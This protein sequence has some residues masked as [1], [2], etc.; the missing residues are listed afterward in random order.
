MAGSGVGGSR[1]ALWIGGGF[2][3]RRYPVTWRHN[4]GHHNIEHDFVA[5]LIDYG[6]TLGSRTLLGFVPFD[7]DGINQ[8]AVQHPRLKA[9]GANGKYLESQGIHCWGYA[10]NPALAES[11]RLVAEY[12][13]ELYDDF[14]PNAD[15]LLI[16][17]S[18]L[19]L[20]SGPG[21]HHA[22]EFELV[23]E[24]SA[25]YSAGHPDGE[26][27]V[28]PHYFRTDLGRTSWYDDRWRLVFTSH[29]T[30]LDDWLIG[31]A[32]YTFYADYSMMTGDPARFGG[33][34]GWSPAAG[35]T[36]TCRRWSSSPTPRSAAR[37]A[38][39]R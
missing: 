6:H 2:R 3:S 29:S 7:F 31:R 23:R 32:A 28:Y 17:S 36:A 4:R 9:F 22:L 18:D 20:G 11:R 33:R 12:V 30:E 16:E 37:W 39:R 8:Y 27:V 35:S 14:Y 19:K 26:V 21:N 38:S 24:I 15:G 25:D 13:K 34:A 1:G 10:L 5:G